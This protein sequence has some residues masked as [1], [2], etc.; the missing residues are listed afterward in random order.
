[1][2]I[3]IYIYNVASVKTM[4]LWLSSHFMVHEM[5]HAAESLSLFF[6]S[7]DHGDHLAVYGLVVQTRPWKY[8]HVSFLKHPK[9]FVQHLSSSINILLSSIIYHPFSIFSIIYHLSS[10]IYNPSG[11]MII[12]IVSISFE[13]GH[14]SEITPH[15]VCI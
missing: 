1:M 14:S 13:I 11:I 12:I 9:T 3:H 6:S 10:I 8:R 2:H 5:V 15:Y 7:F 4:V